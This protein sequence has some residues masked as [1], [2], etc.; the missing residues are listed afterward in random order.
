VGLQRYGQEPSA[1]LVA[2][3]ERA[4]ATVDSVAPY[5]YAPA[6]DDARVRGLIAEIDA[7]RVDAIAFTSAAQVDRLWQVARDAG[8]EASLP[9]ALARTR[10]AAIGPV[11][12]T[13][14]AERGARVDIAPEK[15]FVM[16]HLVGLIAGALA[17]AS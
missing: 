1:E 9:A 3:L 15:P 7:G 2:F 11:V 10:V 8:V 5:V 17:Q 16:K 12:V 14:L 6:A 13:A 4:G